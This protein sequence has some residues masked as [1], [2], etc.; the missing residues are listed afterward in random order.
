MHTFY[1]PG[2]VLAETGRF[3][4]RRG[5]TGKEGLVLWAGRRDAGNCAYVLMNIKAGDAWPHG[6][7]LRF[8][9]MKKL[10]QLLV[11]NE[12]VLLAQVHSH[13]D[14]IPH[15]SGDEENPASH[16]MGYISIVVPD[17][18]LH[19]IDLQRCFVYEYQSQLRWR[20]LDNGQKMQWFRMLPDGVH[21]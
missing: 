7:R 15:S 1:I 6:V 12:M 9:Q 10:T 3:L 2:L 13:P 14:N 4:R 19:G 21:L 11:S 5:A 16:K 20:E 8:Q 17:L 18:G